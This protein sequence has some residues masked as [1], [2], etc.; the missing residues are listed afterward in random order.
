MSEKKV[1]IIGGGAEIRGVR[2]GEVKICDIIRLGLV[3]SGMKLGIAIGIS[4]AR[5]RFVTD[6]H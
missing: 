4:L 3:K 5:L 2:N 1:S 6:S